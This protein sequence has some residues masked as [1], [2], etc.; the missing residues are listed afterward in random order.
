MS[1][2]EPLGRKSHSPGKRISTKVDSSAATMMTLPATN[3]GQRLSSSSFF[4]LAKLAQGCCLLLQY[5]DYSFSMR[6]DIRT[7]LHR[8]ILRRTLA[9]GL[10]TAFAVSACG[11]ADPV[12]PLEAIRQRQA[13]GDYAGS[14]EPLRE[15]L[16]TRPDDPEANYLYGRALALTQRSHIAT[17]SLRKA[18]ADPEW[19]VPAG[20]QLAFAALSA[21]D[22]NEVVEIAELVLEQDPEYVPVLVM[23]AN[24]H[25]HWKKD[26][27]L[28]LA[29]AER[30]LELDPN[31][32]EAYE[33]RI[34][35]LLSLE[36]LEEASQALAE[37]GER[38]V[39]EG[40]DPKVLAWHCSTTAAFE[41]ESG[42]L[43]QARATWLR[44]LEA[45]P[46][47]LEVVSNAIAFYDEQEEFERSLELLRAAYAAEPN[48]RALRVTLAHRLRRQG[49][50]AGA[51]AVL[52][53]ATNAEDPPLA[54]AAWVDLAKLHQA[55][56][57][58]GAAADALKEA[59]DLA[60]AAGSSDP[61]LLFD[62]ADNLVLAD[63][64]DAALAVAAELSVPAHRQLILGR[65]AQEQHDP[66][67]ALAEF[68]EALRLWPDNPWARYYTALAA[69]ELGDF[70]RALAEY[71]Y[72]TR[73]APGATDARTRGAELLLARGSAPSARQMLLTAAGSD[74]LETE[75]Q[76]LS[77]RLSGMLNDMKAV[78]ASLERI[79]KSQ[80]AWAG[81][82]LAAAAEGVAASAGPAVALGVLA[83]APGVD[84]SEP[85]YAAALRALVRYAHEAGETEAT[86]SALQEILVARSD[87][88]VFQE[89]RGLDLELS[90]APSDAVQEAYE[91]AS[92]LEPRNAGALAGLG[93]LASSTDPEAALA[94]FDRAAAADPSD[95]APKLQAARLLAAA[96]KIELAASRL[97]AL[98]REHPFEATA[99]AERARL[100]LERDVATAQTLDRARRAANFGGG[101][102]ALDLLSQV[103][104]R[105]GELERASRVA[106]RARVLRE[107][108]A[109]K[110]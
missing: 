35:A 45:H 23:R 89:I 94:F 97:D 2:T 33:P 101:P 10:I 93:R 100:D 109:Q 56:G 13:S 83:S 6:P 110:D 15:L 87:S 20:A 30:V 90:G 39:E 106:E 70:E 72:A 29:D 60:Q 81:R 51:E 53:E 98:L 4:T 50:A 103:H 75:G 55:L 16:Q 105:R 24:A 79:E 38:L 57:D 66:V 5:V 31:A 44:C 76:L 46:T 52:R 77:M 12:D 96:G 1:S 19:L 34:L 95:P 68:D 18:M 21:R 59:V 42:E 99:A 27:E 9:A 58:H 92:E 40:A 73:I 65:V 71:R 82:A 41:Q 17:W 43:E 22:F 64:F 104:T 86:Q 91:R 8:F 14:V 63:R 48:S 74:P 25:A 102:D 88:G 84:F 36:R 47:N 11:E 32:L 78:S 107:K 3:Q 80:P 28:A 85:R 26:P 37:A 69:E 62:Y 49:D 67:R 61:E 7:T 108:P 54:A